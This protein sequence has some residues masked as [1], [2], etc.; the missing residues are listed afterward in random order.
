MSKHL[1][2][3]VFNAVR[4]WLNYTDPI[5]TSQIRHS[6]EFCSHL[7]YD[8]GT[9]FEALS[10]LEDKAGRIARPLDDLEEHLYVVRLLVAAEVLPKTSEQDYLKS[11]ADFRLAQEQS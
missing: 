4:A 10:I 7:G 1:T 6:L 3:K 9:A 11:L 5:N 2:S 8:V